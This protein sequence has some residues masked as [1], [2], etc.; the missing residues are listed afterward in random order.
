MIQH[1]TWRDDSTAHS[2]DSSD[3]GSTPWADL[4]PCLVLQVR[5]GSRTLSN[6]HSPLSSSCLQL[7]LLRGPA[8][9]LLADAQRTLC[10]PC[11]GTACLEG[12]G[13]YEEEDCC[14]FGPGPLSLSLAPE[15]PFGRVKVVSAT[16]APTWAQR[17]LLDSGG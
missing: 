14:F 16:L 13:Q 4:P 17:L 3:R 7:D 15:V 8:V 1:P 11:S 5:L 2:H 9:P 10:Y 12:D 6:T